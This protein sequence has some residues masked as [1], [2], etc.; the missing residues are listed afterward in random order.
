MNLL[1]C[2]PGRV[3]GSEEYLVRQLIGLSELDHEFEMVPFVPRPFAAAHPELAIYPMVAARSSGSPRA[4]RV[5]LEHSWLAVQA[6]KRA[7]GLLHHG[8]GTVPRTTTR[9]ALLTIHD[10]QWLEYPH[11]V[12]AAKR[13]YLAAVTPRSIRRAAVITT[14]SEFVK[15]TV[16]EYYGVDPD[17]VVTV[18][19]GIEPALGTAATDASTLRSKYRLGA[20]PIVVFPAMT[21]PHKRH[22]FL[23]DLVAGPASAPEWRDVTLVLTGG[24]GSGEAA[25]QA[26]IGALGDAG[27]RVVRTGRVPAADRDGLIAMAEALVFPSEYEGFGAPVLEA[28]A[29]GT[30]VVASDRAALPEVVG[31]AGLVLPLDREAWAGALATVDERRADLVAAG[32]RRAAEFTTARSATDLLAA[33]RQA[34]GRPAR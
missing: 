23:V 30:P 24:E 21:H 19:H 7:V 18:R 31:D 13:R 28:M 25:L 4:V 22:D 27:H 34:C 33:Y 5:A 15:A 16:V 17:R 1:W 14:P 2:R 8:G 20:G 26:R 32:R 29:L 10:L 3:G 12:S 6:R 11:Y 9:P